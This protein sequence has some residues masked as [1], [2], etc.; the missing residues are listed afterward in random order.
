MMG[1]ISGSSTAN[2]VTTGTFT[3][4]LMK[5]V[6]FKPHVAGGV[7]VAAS[8]SGQFLPPIMG[9]AAFIMAEMTNI[10]YL[11]IIKS[12]L[13]PAI[14]SYVAILFMVHFEASKNGI[15]GMAKSELVSGRKLLVQ[16]G[17]LIIP[18]L[19]LMYF[20][21]IERRSIFNAAFFAIIAVL[22]IAFFAHRFRERIGRSLL[23]AGG[24]CLLTFGLQFSIDSINGLL[25]QV[26]RSFFGGQFIRWHSDISLMVVLGIVVAVSFALLHK[27]FKTEG[28]PL[29]Y[30][31]KQ[32]L[33]GLELAARNSL[34]VA[35]ACA[36]AGILIGVL[37]LSGLNT[38]FTRI[39]MSYSEGIV[40]FLPAF[41]VFEHTQLYVALV[42]TVFACLIL[43]LGLPTTATYIVLAAT[44]APALVGLGLPVLTA[45]LFVLYYGVLADDTPPINLPAYAAAGI[46]NAG[47]L[48]TGVQGFK[49]DSGA[50]LLPFAFVANP[51]LLLLE[52]ST[53]WYTVLWSIVTATVGIVLFASFIQNWL[54]ARYN[55]LERTM[56][57][58]SA[59]TLIHSSWVTDVVGIGVLATL[60]GTQFYRTR[61]PKLP[62]TG[63]AQPVE[64]H[65]VSK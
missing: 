49:F 12:A 30:G 4:P 62:L 3:I 63:V 23:Y 28:T 19:V 29:R 9:A 25:N 33:A 45:H 47:P 55:G 61:G 42:L 52:T 16:Q 1:S 64:G 57:L 6:G 32:L 31:L 17:Y 41:L 44:V 10:P 27:K 35:V 43:G 34:S 22:V 54:I 7:E 20:L 65:E 11:E 18:I 59:L 21:V 48:K 50:L 8:S 5:R 14:L 60:A 46:A 58:I 40:D 39:V 2:A 51:N 24:L 15:T 37:Q 38:K 53:P 13:I 56:A 26:N 36:T